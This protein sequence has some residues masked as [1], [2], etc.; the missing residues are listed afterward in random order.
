MLFTPEINVKY[1]AT[2]TND[3]SFTFT[4]LDNKVPTHVRLDKNTG[5]TSITGTQF[6]ICAN[7]T[8]REVQTSVFTAIDDSTKTETIYTPGAILLWATVESI[9]YLYK[10]KAG[11]VWS[12]CENNTLDILIIEDTKWPL[13]CVF[14][15]IY[16]SSNIYLGHD[17]KLYVGGTQQYNNKYRE[18]SIINIHTDTIY[19]VK[20]HNIS[21]ISPQLDKKYSISNNSCHVTFKNVDQFPM[22]IVYATGE[23]RWVNPL[24]SIFENKDCTG[25]LGQ[26][27]QLDPVVEKP[28]NDMVDCPKQFGE[29]EFKFDNNI[30][31]SNKVVMLTKD[32]FKYLN[33]GCIGETR[34]IKDGVV[35]SSFNLGTIK[36][37]NFIRMVNEIIT[38]PIVNGIY[39][40]VYDDNKNFRVVVTST[41][42]LDGVFS[43]GTF[44]YVGGLAKWSF[45]KDGTVSDEEGSIVGSMFIEMHKPVNDMIDCPKQFGEYE[46]EFDDNRSSAFKVVMLTKDTFKY[47]NGGCIGETRT[48]KDGSVYSSKI[49]TSKFIRMVNEIVSNPIVNGVYATIDNNTG[50]VQ[51]V[52]VTSKTSDS[53]DSH[54]YGELKYADGKTYKFNKSGLAFS[55]NFNFT[56]VGS[57]FIEMDIVTLEVAWENELNQLIAKE[58]EN[59]DKIEQVEDEL[60]KLDEEYK[61]QRAILKN[62]KYEYQ[63]I[64][65]TLWD[66]SKTHKDYKRICEAS[67]YLP[68]DCQ[69]STISKKRLLNVLEKQ[70]E[71]SMFSQR[72]NIKHKIDLITKMEPKD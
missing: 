71:C 65:N 25:Y 58:N 57:M 50:C 60:T 22:E 17:M 7:G 26:I 68:N 64:Q 30:F 70:L 2:C 47:L 3:T 34:T 55:T 61:K 29:Y 12:V 42:Y 15:N 28:V 66:G 37:S 10:P 1:S 49:K 67:Y 63:T 19:I 14:H 41:K 23:S 35:F 48:I 59:N 9:D 54:V 56:I 27:Q 8:I 6:F 16:N 43:D 62:K 38:K 52:V 53:D 33:G 72:I 21:A 24:G 4:V 69:V 5:N 44:K 32:S 36:T 20:D 40:I 46:F 11:Q 45:N 39:E 18:P 51:R 13:K 31:F